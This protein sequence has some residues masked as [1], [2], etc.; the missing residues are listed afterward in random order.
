MYDYTNFT[1]DALNTSHLLLDK[2]L[3][4]DMSALREMND[5]GEV[6]YHWVN[7]SQQLADVLT[8][9]GASKKKLFDLLDQACLDN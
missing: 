8:K 4:I 9:R 2:R 5:K 7:S 1:W 6:S 3:R